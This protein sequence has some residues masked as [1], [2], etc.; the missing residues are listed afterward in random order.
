MFTGPRSFANELHSLGD[1]HPRNKNRPIER[2]TRWSA[3]TERGIV[4]N[5]LIPLPLTA[6]RAPSVFRKHA[7]SHA[8]LARRLDPPARN[9][10]KSRQRGREMRE[11]RE[12]GKRASGEAREKFARGISRRPIRHRI[13]PA[14]LHADDKSAPR[15]RVHSTRSSYGRVTT[16]V[17]SQQLR[18]SRRS[19]LVA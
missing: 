17:R 15:A 7:I 18:G 11:T 2:I 12:T 16:R 13:G 9:S 8:Q 5:A 4:P 1:L 10:A 14:N 19:N 6:S 3:T